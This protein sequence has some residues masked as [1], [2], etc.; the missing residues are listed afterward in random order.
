MNGNMSEKNPG[1]VKTIGL[2]GGLS[3]EATVTYIR[4]IHEE[5][6]HRFG[7]SR[8]VSLH[9]V[10]IGHHELEVLCAARDWARLKARLT[11][12]ARRLTAAGAEKILFCS[13]VL[14]VV[15]D[16]VAKSV[17]IPLLSAP[18]VVAASLVR[19]GISRVGLLGA[20]DEREARV[21]KDRLDAG[22][23]TDV[24]V[25]VATDQER[26]GKI[27]R[28]EL[29]LGVVNE[30]SR[31]EI[32]HMVAAFRKAGARTVIL[33][34][35][36]LRLLFGQA[37]SVLPVFDAAELHAVAAVDWAFGEQNVANLA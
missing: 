4:L 2:I 7:N 25:P 5:V 12:A 37:E 1:A 10:E 22:L 6:R 32:V 19:T 13:S 15:F 28:E 31:A 26:I 8:S 23:V 9:A 36:E 11:C 14:H 27:I 20:F 33:V 34:P 24:L 16:E 35:P 17:D 18:D 30:S 29:A 21:W 3:A